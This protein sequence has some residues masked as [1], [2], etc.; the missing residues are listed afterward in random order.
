MM[1]SHRV[2]AG[3]LRAL[4][5]KLTARQAFQRWGKELPETITRAYV[6]DPEKEFEFYHGIFPRPD[7][8]IKINTTGHAAGKNRPY[9]SVYIARQDQQIVEEDGYYEFPASVVRWA[10]SP[11]ELYGYGPGH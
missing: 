2:R 4:C 10:T 6:E 7:K 9:A 1:K 5:F 8:D 11:G 3:N